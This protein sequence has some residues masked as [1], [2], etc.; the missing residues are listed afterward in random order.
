MKKTVKVLF[1]LASCG[2]E[3]NPSSPIIS[4]NGLNDYIDVRA[5]HTHK[6]LLAT[7][8][9]VNEYIGVR[10]ADAAHKVEASYDK[11]KSHMTDRNITVND[12][13][14]ASAKAVEDTNYYVDVR[15]KAIDTKSEDGAMKVKDKTTTILDDIRNGDQ[16]EHDKMAKMDAETE[17]KRAELEAKMDAKF[18]EVDT[19][20]TLEEAKSA[21]LSAL[22]EEL[23]QTS[24]VME[25]IAE[26]RIYALE[27][28]VSS[29][30]SEMEMDLA[31]LNAS[32][33]S[34]IALA[35]GYTNSEVASA[36]QEAKDYAD[37]NDAYEADTTLDMNAILAA[38]EAADDA[39]KAEIAGIYA[40][41]TALESSTELIDP[42]GDNPGHYDEVLI[43]TV[44]GSLVSYFKAGNKEFL[45]VL[46][47]GNY[48]TTDKQ[49]CHF[50]VDANGNVID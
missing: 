13:Y 29:L 10:S 45:S 21:A 28:Y 18:S 36:L 5:T 16:D 20:L 44:D 40:T 22:I 17:A 2:V 32:L 1:L 33:S 15:T 35:N 31:E 24:Q 9:N 4:A 23:D 19:R 42:C 8:S 47:Q 3:N 49:Q 50:S 46:G 26:A 12:F 11:A 43:R 34:A 27:V 30:R 41:Q 6:K 7:G 37:D 38:I 14:D 48:V 25:A 39:V